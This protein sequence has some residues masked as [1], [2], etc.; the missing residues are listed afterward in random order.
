[1]IKIENLSFRYPGNKTDTLQDISFEINSGEKTALL[2]SSGS[3]KTTL[4]RCINGL[5]SDFR[6]HI[7]SS[8]DH[9][10]TKTKSELK[11]PQD[12]A[13]VFQDHALIPHK[14]VLWHVCCGTLAQYNPL[15]ALGPWRKAD[16]DRALNLIN[17]VGLDGRALDRI[18][19][20]SGGQRQRVAIARALMQE[21]T[22]ILA[23]EPIASLDPG[24]SKNILDLFNAV[25]TKRH[26]CLI[27]LHQV[28]I[29]VTFADRIIALHNGR[30]L[31]N[32]SAQ[33][34]TPELHEEVFS[35]PITRN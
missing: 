17:Q 33:D 20:L 8:Q 31:F 5:L 7:G 12:C 18:N 9:A 16:I 25:I 27:S 24:V 23:D 15:R 21:P 26:A 6:G 4:L 10:S 29:A 1:M 3:G 28:D 22:C 34:F 14:T 32:G 2:G 19:H 13:M 30:L 35:Q 11:W